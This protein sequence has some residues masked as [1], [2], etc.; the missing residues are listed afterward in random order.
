MSPMIFGF[1]LLVHAA[2]KD[3][4]ILGDVVAWIAI[5]GILAFCRWTARWGQ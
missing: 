2:V 4:R 5:I 1:L 3:P